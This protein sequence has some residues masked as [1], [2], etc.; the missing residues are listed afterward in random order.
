MLRHHACVPL[1]SLRQNGESVASMRLY[2]RGIYL[3]A[4]VGCWSRSSGLSCETMR[5]IVREYRPRHHGN[6]DQSHHAGLND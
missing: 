6:P 2:H 3:S 4:I 1:E 5:Q